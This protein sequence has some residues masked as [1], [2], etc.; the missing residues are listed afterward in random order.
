MKDLLLQWKEKNY[1][2]ECLSK[3]ISKI[4]KKRQEL[5]EIK[6]QACLLEGKI[7]EYLDREYSFLEFPCVFDIDGICFLVS[8]SEHFP[9]ELYIEL[10][11][12][13]KI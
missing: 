9:A 5:S 6:Q 2:I 12:V 1:K 11:T 3:E 13:R 7:K 10:V 8:L 4:E